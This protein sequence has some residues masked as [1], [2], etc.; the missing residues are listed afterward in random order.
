[1]APEGDSE[2]QSVE[3]S[4]DAVRPEEALMAPGV[5]PLWR[6]YVAAAGTF[7]LYLA[8]WTY[9]TARQY[10]SASTS[11]SGPTGRRVS[12]AS[13]RSIATRRRGGRS[14]RSSVRSPPASCSSST[15][16]RR[17]SRDDHDPRPVR[18][19]HSSR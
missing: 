19:S 10:G 12:T 3:S 14:G 13:T 11:R 9:R 6:L 1:M 2:L 17:R 8:V 18:R 4:T 15:E 5:I 7:C 16:E